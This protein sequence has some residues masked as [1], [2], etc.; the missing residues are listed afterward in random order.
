MKEVIHEKQI[1]DLFS[2]KEKVV[3]ITGAGGLGSALAYGYLANGAT[4]IL[5]SR[6][7][8]K[9][10]KV[11]DHLLAK[12]YK[13][14]E[15][16]TFDQTVKGQ[17]E[18]LAQKIVAKYG[19]IDVLVNTA[20]IAICHPA[21]E[22]PEEDIR[23]I[24]DVNLTSAMFITQA[25]GKTMIRRHQGKI[26]H[27]GS[28]GGKL[29]HTFESM[30]Y[31]STKAGLHQMVSAF[32][33]AWGQ[34]NINVNCI[35]PTWIN[36]PMLNGVPVSYYENV[37]KMHVFGRMAEPDDFVGTTIFLSSEASNFIT[38]HTLMVDG[39]WSAGK[40]LSYDKNDP[41]KVML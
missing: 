14:C 16:F 11:V 9:V 31:Q 15:A 8:R 26:I 7:Q 1:K 27:I 35:A 34:Y 28:I 23:K 22:F 40:P 29:V 18:E 30:V 38:G 21:E 17:C 10:Q 6:T 32:A 33:V 41:R 4:V 20:G 3:L 19:K 37:N 12:G 13:D 5:A 2:V 36:T 24:I 25:V 39:G